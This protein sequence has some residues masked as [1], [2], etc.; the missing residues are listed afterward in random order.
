MSRLAKNWNDTENIGGESA[1]S[2][3]FILFLIRFRWFVLLYSDKKSYSMR[4]N[5]G[6]VDGDITVWLPAAC[7]QYYY[8]YCIID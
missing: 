1:G 7:M 6:D 3:L 8:A 2:C 5:D 4:V